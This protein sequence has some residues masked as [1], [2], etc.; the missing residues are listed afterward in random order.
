MHTLKKYIL[1]G[2]FILGLLFW[3]CD[4]YLDIPLPT[5]SLFQEQV[6]MERT[7]TAAAVNSI[8]AILSAE[9]PLSI[10]ALESGLYTDELTVNGSLL[11]SVN[12]RF[13]QNDL[14]DRFTAEIY[15]TFYPL[16]YQANAIL[17]GIN[18]VPANFN[19]D[20]YV[21]EALFV[22]AFLLFNLANYYGD[23]PL[24]LS[25][26]I[27]LNN[28]SPRVPAEA[29]YQQLAEDLVLAA[30]L[31]EWEYLAA[32]GT[33]TSSKARPNRAAAKTL[34]AKVYLYT[35]E[36]DLA[37]EAI[38]EVFA[39]VDQPGLIDLNEVFLTDSDALIWGII[40]NQNPASIPNFVGDRFLYLSW[41]GDGFSFAQTYMAPNLVDAFEENDQRK[42]NWTLPFAVGPNVFHFP[43]KYKSEVT[44]VEAFAAMRM[45]ELYLMRAEALLFLGDWAG[46]LENLNVVRSRAGLDPLVAMDSDTVLNAL[47]QELRIEFFS[48]L[49]HRLFDLKRLGLID[50]VMQ[51]TVNQK[52]G[53]ATWEPYKQN[54]PI[55]ISEI[56]ANPN[57][58]Q[59]EGY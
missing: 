29:V 49:S 54:W 23:I 16:V 10:S 27:E 20:Q 58:K 59:T 50:E 19:R 42:R 40:P 2:P 32:D 38:T 44:G 9:Y 4:D 1:K 8:F 52:R 35:Q 33:P 25:T 51:A 53:N 46:A 24:P 56:L 11:A 7:T 55:P 3:G 28:T 36:Y 37:L 34:L 22:R 14:T 21:W 5:N 6:F 57:L 41:L 13:Y 47:V 43:N 12:G 26:D 31:L 48:E 17:E 45:A 39:N 18:K 15:S 30:D